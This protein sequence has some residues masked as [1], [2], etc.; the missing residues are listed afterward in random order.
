MA[1][2]I[3][4]KGQIEKTSDEKKKPILEDLQLNAMSELYRRLSELIAEGVVPDLYPRNN[5][6][7]ATP[8]MFREELMRQHLIFERLR[9]T[10]MIFDDIEE[11]QNP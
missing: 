3:Y 9:P 11:I 8:L 5:P 2:I 1:E 6:R 4:K 10:H 7:M